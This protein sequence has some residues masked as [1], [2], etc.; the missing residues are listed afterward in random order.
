MSFE[1]SVTIWWEETQKIFELKGSESVTGCSKNQLQLEVEEQEQAGKASCQWYCND[2][3][4]FAKIK[5]TKNSN[6]CQTN[7]VI[8]LDFKFGTYLLFI[9]KLWE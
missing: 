5:A 7:Q 3:A 2:S 8:E 9:A 4:Q 1:L 6:L